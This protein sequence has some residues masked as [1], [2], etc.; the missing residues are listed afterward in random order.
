MGHAAPE[1]LGFV[2]SLGNL[3]RYLGQSLGTTVS[4]GVLYGSMSA[5]AGERVSSFAEAGPDLFMHGL[6]TVFYLLAGLVA[7]A[8]A[9]SLARTLVLDRRRPR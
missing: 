4:I 8:L 1:M 6:A 7:V 2:G 5:R 3:M 9:L